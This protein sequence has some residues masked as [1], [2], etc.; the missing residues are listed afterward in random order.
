MI[1][2]QSAT[3]RV[4]FVFTKVANIH[5]ITSK[6]FY[7]ILPIYICTNPPVPSKLNHFIY[8]WVSRHVIVW[9]LLCFFLDH[10]SNEKNYRR[11]WKLFVCYQ[12]WGLRVLSLYHQHQTKTTKELFPRLFLICLFFCIHH[13]NIFTD[14][15]PAC[16]QLLVRQRREIR[17]C[18]HTHLLRRQALD[19]KMHVSFIH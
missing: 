3:P 2:Y 16:A 7:Y 13:F 12:F 9:W 17:C 6:M 10:N 18:V 1:T 15:D 11:L 14:N 8:M 4:S 19:Y 5:I